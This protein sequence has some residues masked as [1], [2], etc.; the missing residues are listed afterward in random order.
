MKNY[1]CGGDEK[2]EEFKKFDSF[3]LLFGTRVVFLNFHGKV[4]NEI[5]KFSHSM[6]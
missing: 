5:D 3:I 4:Q 6:K 1:F 2:S